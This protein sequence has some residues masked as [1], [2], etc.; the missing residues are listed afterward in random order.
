M[1]AFAHFDASSIPAKNLALIGSFFRGSRSHAKSGHKDTAC[2]TVYR[3]YNA[4]H[5][6]C[7]LTVI[8]RAFELDYWE[9]QPEREREREKGKLRRLCICFVSTCIL[10]L[11]TFS[12]PPQNPLWTPQKKNPRAVKKMHLAA[13][14]NKKSTNP[15][16]QILLPCF[17]S[18]PHRPADPAQ[19]MN[20]HQHIKEH[21]I[22]QLQL[23]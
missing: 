14:P 5:M 18:R 11:P 9:S 3:V 12:F 1:F 16:A 7:F 23:Q 8:D 6:I 20:T 2:I 4:I 15:Y 22:H 10:P 17:T 21:R 19:K 13:L